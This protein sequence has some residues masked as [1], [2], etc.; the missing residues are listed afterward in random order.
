MAGKRGPAPKPDEEKRQVRVSVYF[1]PK[2]LA[3][4]DVRRGGMERSEWLRRA[5]LDK[6]L[7]PAIPE[8]NREAWAALART[9]ANLNQIARSMNAAGQVHDADLVGILV[10]L[11]G[12]VA[13]LRGDLVGLDQVKDLVKDQ[14]KDLVKD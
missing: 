4:L 5:G 7:A 11:H 3:D 1:T 13:R 14:V 2:E 6:R 10:E 12:Q 8:L 9:A